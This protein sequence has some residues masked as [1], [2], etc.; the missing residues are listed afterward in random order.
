MAR[1]DITLTGDYNSFRRLFSGDYQ[2]SIPTMHNILPGSQEAVLFSSL[3]AK[4]YLDFS[5][6]MNIIQ[7]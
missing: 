3:E 2:S 4:I 6:E 5:D 7:K 1:N